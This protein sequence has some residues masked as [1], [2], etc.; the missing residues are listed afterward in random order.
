MTMSIPQS[1]NYLLQKDL[2]RCDGIKL[3][4]AILF[5]YKDGIEDFQKKL[6]S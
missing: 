6:D 4:A 2:Q 5:S 3:F 1:G